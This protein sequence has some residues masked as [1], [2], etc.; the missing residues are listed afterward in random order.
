MITPAERHKNLAHSRK[1]IADLQD[2]LFFPAPHNIGRGNTGFAGTSA[3]IA[4][5][6][7]ETTATPHAESVTGST[8]SV[9][10]GAISAH[11]ATWQIIA[12]FLDVR[13]AFFSLLTDSS[14][15]ATLRK[16]E[17][18]QTVISPE[19]RIL[20]SDRLTCTLC[21]VKT[22]SWKIAQFEV[23]PGIRTSW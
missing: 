17:F 23:D 6:G 12:F 9:G 13:E 21:G 4:A 15:C 19:P 2:S 16:A 7:H 10:S 3:A 11:S 20:L 8:A 14:D 1:R 18:Q 22:R 5:R